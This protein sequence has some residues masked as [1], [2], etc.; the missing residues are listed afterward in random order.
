MP[1]C[2]PHL[3]KGTSSFAGSECKVPPTGR[4]PDLIR[5]PP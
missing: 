4:P 3:G 1:K 5:R 2:S